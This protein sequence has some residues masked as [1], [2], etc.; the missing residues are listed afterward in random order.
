M[1]TGRLLENGD[2]RAWES[3]VRH[4]GKWAQALE[5]AW[6]ELAECE[7]PGEGR[8]A[9]SERLAADPPLAGTG[10][11][12]M[13][14]AGFEAILERG[15]VTADEGDGVGQQD[16]IQ[17][18]A[19]GAG[20]RLGMAKTGWDQLCVNDGTAAWIAGEICGMNR[21][22]RRAG[23][24][25]QFVTFD[26]YFHSSPSFHEPSVCDPPGCAYPCSFQE[27]LPE[28]NQ[29]HNVLT[30]FCGSRRSLSVASVRQA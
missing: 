14:D 28:R 16:Q 6:L 4:G 29:S 23:I 9:G 19:D 5:T 3:P 20:V 18:A 13:E 8:S 21:L 24:D 30:G 2:R 25:R 22:R 15:R 26:A 10:A 1:R 17:G 7:Q 27:D 12:E 11:V